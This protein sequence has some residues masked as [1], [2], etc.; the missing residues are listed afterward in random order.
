MTNCSS[1]AA[2]NDASRDAAQAA[3]WLLSLS[4]PLPRF[5]LTRSHIAR[6]RHVVVVPMVTTVT[7][8][9][10][11]A[12]VRGVAVILACLRAGEVQRSAPLSLLRTAG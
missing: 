1:P 2:T 6:R 9:C 11:K 3:D 10:A 5:D 8:A 7:T 4:S 12:A